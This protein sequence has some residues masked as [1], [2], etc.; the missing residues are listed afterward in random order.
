MQPAMDEALQALGTLPKA[1]PQAQPSMFA[2]EPQAKVVARPRVLVP[3]AMPKARP[4]A[5]EVQSDSLWIHAIGPRSVL[6]LSTLSL[7]LMS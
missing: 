4:R 6:H 1:A 2:V 3:K 7:I 5:Q